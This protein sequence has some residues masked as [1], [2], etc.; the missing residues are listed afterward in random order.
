MMTGVKS[1]VEPDLLEFFDDV[2]D[3]L[4]LIFPSKGEP[5]LIPRP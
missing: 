4:V 3:V 5:K 1:D 2:I